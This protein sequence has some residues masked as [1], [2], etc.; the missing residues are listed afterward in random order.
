MYLSLR[1]CEHT[2]GISVKGTT[3]SQEN[4]I[5]IRF[6]STLIISIPMSDVHCRVPN[7]LEFGVSE[8]SGKWAN[9]TKFP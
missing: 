3:V 9:R 5:L 1:A 4:R 8:C 7:G 6:E 2:G